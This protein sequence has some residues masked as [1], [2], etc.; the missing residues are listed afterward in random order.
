MRINPSK[1]PTER[2]AW[3]RSLSVWR[4]QYSPKRLVMV[5]SLASISMNFTYMALSQLGT[6]HRLIH[7]IIGPI[8]DECWI[9]EIEARAQH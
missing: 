3:I 2:R 5:K 4:S 9:H 1:D 7:N 6:G 8:A